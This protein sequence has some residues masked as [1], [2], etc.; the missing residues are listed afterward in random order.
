MSN[1]I[2]L[3]TENVELP[4]P[5][6]RSIE[7]QET[8]ARQAMWV[9]L[10]TETLFFGTLFASYTM[11][12]FTYPEDFRKASHE[13]S[14]AFGSVNTVVLLTSSFFMARAVS[15]ARTNLNRPL[16]RSLLITAFFGVTFLTIKGFEY[17]YD[18]RHD[19]VPSAMMRIEGNPGTPPMH[20]FMFLYWVM[21][22]FHAL[23]M[24]VGIGLLLYLSV[25]VWRSRFSKVRS[26]PVEV[27]GLYW[28][29]V[30]AIWLFL[31]PTLYLAGVGVR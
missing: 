19:S 23:H 5:Q 3:T 21:T 17:A 6:F 20:L 13:M 26:G 1:P 28:H 7:Q 4:E 15:A 8:A 11:L 31:Y 9:F 25:R 29:F 14:L 30:D 12:R 22:G 18:I 2:E 27:I 16:L 10:A 24:M